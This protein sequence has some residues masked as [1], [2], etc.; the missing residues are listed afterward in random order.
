MEHKKTPGLVSLVVLVCLLLGSGLLLVLVRTAGQ[1]LVAQNLRQEARL[2]TE[3]LWSME[4]VRTGEPLLKAGER[5]A[6]PAFRFR[7]DCPP[8]SFRLEGSQKGLIHQERLELLDEENWLLLAG[9]RYAVTMPGVDEN[10]PFLPGGIYQNGR[11]NR[12]LLVD[13]NRLQQAAPC[14]LP[15]ERRLALPLTGEFCWGKDGWV[16]QKQLIGR[17]ILVSGGSVI[18]ERSSRVQGDFRILS[19]GRVTVRPGARLENV[20]LYAGGDMVLKAGCHV[21]GILAARGRVTV[22]E[23]AEFTPDVR[24]LEPFVTAWK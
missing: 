12:T 10:L 13:W 5:K 2:W 8:V 7:P 11:A 15:L 6:L 19:Q 14:A 23:G 9:E 20:Y 16:L 17:G 18:F 3:L 1:E 21:K 22:E 4:R 24:V